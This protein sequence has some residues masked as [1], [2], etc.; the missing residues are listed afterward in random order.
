M[1]NTVHVYNR[2]YV[3]I[4]RNDYGHFQTGPLSILGQQEPGFTGCFN[5][6]EYGGEGI[7]FHMQSFRLIVWLRSK[8]V[9]IILNKNWP[10]VSVWLTTEGFSKSLLYC[11]GHEYKTLEEHLARAGSNTLS[12]KGEDND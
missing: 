8:E 12:G 10:Q 4:I 11:V 7:I 5:Y 2:D 9:E 1:L 6:I 3:I